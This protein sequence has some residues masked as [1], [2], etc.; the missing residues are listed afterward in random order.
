MVKKKCYIFK[1]QILIPPV[2]SRPPSRTD[3][4]TKSVYDKLVTKLINFLLIKEGR[5]IYS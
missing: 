2:Q 4:K 3:I 5:Y 1:D